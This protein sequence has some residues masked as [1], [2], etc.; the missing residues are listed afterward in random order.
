VQPWKWLAENAHRYGFI[1]TVYSERWHYV[2]VGETAGAKRFSKI[3]KTH[4]SW[5]GL[6]GTI[7]AKEK[8]RRRRAEQARRRRNRS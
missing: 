1:R 8:A 5:D 6:A 7:P 3:K 4:G 2:F